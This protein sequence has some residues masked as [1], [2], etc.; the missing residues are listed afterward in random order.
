MSIH[1]IDGGK[2]TMDRPLGLRHTSVE[3][4]PGMNT[5]RMQAILDRC[6]SEVTQA[7]RREAKHE[8]PLMIRA[9]LG[10]V[11]AAMELER[12]NTPRLLRYSSP[13]GKAPLRVVK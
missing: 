2:G 11:E 7:D 10:D 3:N 6:A 4:D 8:A 9:M 12:I 13:S 5:P 1:V